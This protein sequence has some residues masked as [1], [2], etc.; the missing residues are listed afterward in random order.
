MN[1]RKAFSPA[2][3]AAAGLLLAAGLAKG[4]DFRVLNRVYVGEQREPASQSTTIFHDGIIFDFLDDPAET[5]IFDPARGQ[6]MLLDLRRRMTAQLGTTEI[7][8]AMTQFR[9]QA[10]AMKKPDPLLQFLVEP[11]FAEQVDRGGTTLTLAGKWMSYRARLFSVSATLAGQYREFSDWY[12][13]LNMVLDPAARPP[14]ARMKLDDA[15]A[16]HNAVAQ[17]VKVAVKS[18]KGGKP[19]T[20]RSTHELAVRLTAA[21]LE[22][23]AKARD[24]LRTFQQVGVEQFYKGNAGKHDERTRAR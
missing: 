14:F 15:L 5:V 8:A 6:F 11:T 22:R 7:A 24:A 12:A 10:M 18:S 17:E 23:V 4:D 19:T 9:R 21:D 3:L 16:R 1:G 13:Q 20:L 2:I